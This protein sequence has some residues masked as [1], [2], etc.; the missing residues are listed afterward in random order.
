VDKNIEECKRFVQLAAD[1][2]GR[3]VKVRPNALP[4]GIPPA[5]TL[6]QIGTAL[7]PCGRAAADAGV[8][9]WVE[10]HGQGTQ[11]PANMKTIM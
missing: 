2:G 5:K 4:P 8:E 3:G 7:I 6:E 10:V 11:V 1:L 9:I